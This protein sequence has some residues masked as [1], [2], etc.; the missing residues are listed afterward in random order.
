VEGEL[1]IKSATAPRDVPREENK[2]FGN[3]LYL[4]AKVDI[5]LVINS[6]ERG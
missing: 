1:A 2:T 3:I 5:L 6:M 4:A